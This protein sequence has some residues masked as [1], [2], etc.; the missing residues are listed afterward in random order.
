M[1]SLQTKEREARQHANEAEDKLKAAVV[2]AGEDA[3]ELGRLRPALD[4]ARRALENEWKSKEEA[5][6]LAA[7]LAGDVGALQ[8]ENMVLEEQVNGEALVTFLVVVQSQFSN[9]LWCLA[10][11]ALQRQLSKVRGQL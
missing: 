5:E 9:T 3:A 11:A 2:K 4:L 10:W 8:R 7:A 1:A 6:G